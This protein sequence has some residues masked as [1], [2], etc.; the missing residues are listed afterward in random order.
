MPVDS[1]ATR[2]GFVVLSNSR[3]CTCLLFVSISKVEINLLF[4]NY[5]AII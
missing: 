1:K 4:M 3:E 2:H 5:T